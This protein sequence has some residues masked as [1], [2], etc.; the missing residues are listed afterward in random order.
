M[1]DNKVKVFLISVGLII[2][3]L[4]LPLYFWRG[5]GCCDDSGF[6]VMAKWMDSDIMPY[7]DYDFIYPPGLLYALFGLKKLFG[8][9]WWIS[10]FFILFTNLI[11]VLITIKVIT[12]SDGINTGLLTGLFLYP[13]LHLFHGFIMHAENF[14][15]LFAILALGIIYGK[16]T[17]SSWRVLFF[18][19]LIGLASLFKQPAIFYLI[20][21]LALL[22]IFM[23]SKK[24]ALKKGLILCYIASFGF[25]IVWVLL[26]V[27]L[28]YRGIILDNFIYLIFW[29]PLAIIRDPSFSSF[30]TWL[31]FYTP[32]FVIIIISILASVKHRCLKLQD[33][34][35]QSDLLWL[36]V[37]LFCLFPLFKKA[38]I[39]YMI[40]SLFAAM[41]LVTKLWM[42]IYNKLKN[43]NFK[44]FSYFGISLI[45]LPLLPPT[46]AMSYGSYF[47]VREKRLEFDRAQTYELGSKIIEYSDPLEPVLHISSDALSRVY[48]MLERRPALRYFF[49]SLMNYEAPSRIKDIVA[50]IERFEI[51]V[52]ILEDYLDSQFEVGQK[53]KFNDALKKNYKE[54]DLKFAINYSRK[55]AIKLYVLDNRRPVERVFHSN[56]FP[57]P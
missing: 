22:V 33:I 6:L 31:F 32:I 47:F 23:F 3:I 37:F 21:Y 9:A 12:K 39:Q 24:V 27:F 5:I 34:F 20:A 48:Y 7:N 45:I 17:D 18:G 52:V 11:L 26:A 40:Y 57:S 50:A 46:L 25:I 53:E 55:T 1:K 49:I 8:E 4:S 44:L 56:I 13:S 36:L 41:I 38:S 29:R 51:P 2:V 30:I 28:L 16:E 14:C 43:N 35:R 15:V 54:I 42:A 10:R 19:L